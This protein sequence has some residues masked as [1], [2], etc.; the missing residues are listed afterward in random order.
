MSTTIDYS[1]KK[2]VVIVGA[3][4]G[5]GR[6]TALAVAK[7]GAV[8][9]VAARRQ[10]KLDTL[11]AEIEA[12]GSTGFALQ[13]D[14][15][16]IA[17]LQ[18]L[19]EQT[20]SRYGKIDV[21]F[22][23]AGVYAAGRFDEMPIDVFHE[24]FAINL[25]GVVN[26]TYAVLPIF[27]EQGKGTLIN[28]SS[29]LGEME[30]ECTIAYST[31]K[32]AITHFTRTLRRELRDFPDIKVCICYPQGVDTEIYEKAANFT[33]K[34]IRT[35]PPAISE[36]QAAD[37]IIEL[38]FKRHIKEDLYVGGSAYWINLGHNIVPDAISNKIFTFTH[39]T[40]KDAEPTPGNIHDPTN[41]KEVPPVDLNK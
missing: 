39:T 28:M 20:V 22:N 41:P 6:Q 11:V 29:I 21:W 25:G 33:G 37:E 12:L 18:K 40:S 32:C 9:V 19:A 1:D 13:V 16:E 38:I 14:V 5:I 36:E 27:K 8:V 10:E 26:G 34:E 3:S 35:P 15:R 17:Q 30:F 4:S 2:V 24:V 23:N 7:R 31:S